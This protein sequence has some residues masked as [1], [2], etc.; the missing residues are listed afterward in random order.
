MPVTIA[1]RNCGS[2]LVIPDHL[3][4]QSVRC[5][6]CGSVM[7]AQPA[8]AQVLVGE[9]R[10]TGGVGGSVAA[11]V[12]GIIGMVAW[13]LPILGFPV[14]LIGLILGCVYVR[15]AEGRGMAV[16]GIV[17]STIG[18]ILTVI[19]AILGAMLAW[20]WQNIQPGH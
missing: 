17:L 13:C 3:L 12:L 18:L 19:N 9:K 20:Q 14:N 1:C 5:G 16:A 2:T 15:H 8:Q 6:H 4:H 10:P 7:V 11:L